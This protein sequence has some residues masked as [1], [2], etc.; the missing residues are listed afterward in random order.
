MSQTGWTVTTTNEAEIIQR[1]K[2][3]TPKVSPMSNKCLVRWRERRDEIKGD[4]AW[5]K[6]TGLNG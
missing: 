5:N 4:E 1:T 3:C 6:E 2:Q